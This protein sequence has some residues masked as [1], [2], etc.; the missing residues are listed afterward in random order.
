MSPLDALAPDQRAVV[1]LVLRPDGRY[2]DVAAVLGIP[3]PAVRSRAHAGLAALA[4]GNGLPAEITAPLADY[5]LGQLSEAD[6]AATHGLMAE[7]A[8]ARAWAAGVAQALAPAAPGPLPEIPGEPEPGAVAPAVGAARPPAEASPSPAERGLHDA[9]AEHPPAD[10]TADA[11]AGEDSEAA[12]GEIS[13]LRAARTPVP[14]RPP[15]SHP[16]ARARGRPRDPHR[17]ASAAPC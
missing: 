6:A 12:P 11:A 8:P 2:E 7:S 9:P 17:R 4:P 10:R 13:G 1:S 15:A 14:S 16:P 5:L 3:V